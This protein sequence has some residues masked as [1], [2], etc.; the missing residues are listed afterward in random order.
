MGEHSSSAASK[1]VAENKQSLFPAR[2]PFCAHLRAKA[3]QNKDQA[4][5]SILKQAESAR[6]SLANT[7]LF[8][9]VEKDWQNSSSAFSQRPQSFHP[10]RST[11]YFLSHPPTPSP[12]VLLASNEHLRTMKPSQHINFQISQVLQPN[13][14]QVLTK[15]HLPTPLRLVGHSALMHLQHE[16]EQP[17]R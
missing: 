9:F 1:C 8:S 7:Y 15:H 14:H 5:C 6:M 3:G 17:R 4:V 2:M 16:R 12:F 13:F 10:T 11:R